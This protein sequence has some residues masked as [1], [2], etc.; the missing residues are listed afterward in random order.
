VSGN[1]DLEAL[2][3]LYDAAL[4]RQIVDRVVLNTDL[5]G[6]LEWRVSIPSCAGPIP[7]SSMA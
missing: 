7:T 1:D 6:D 4:G 2:G 3:L 5:V